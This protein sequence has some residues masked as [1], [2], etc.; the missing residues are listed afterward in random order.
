MDPRRKRG[1]PVERSRWW[2]FVI[3][4]ETIDAD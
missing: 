3:E 2:S 1:P 4:V